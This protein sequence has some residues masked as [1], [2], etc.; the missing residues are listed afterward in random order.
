MLRHFLHY[1]TKQTASTLEF[2]YIYSIHSKKRSVDLDK[3]GRVTSWHLLCLGKPMACGKAHVKQSTKFPD[4]FKH[5][6]RSPGQTFP[7]VFFVGIVTFLFFEEKL[8]F[9]H[10]NLF[11]TEA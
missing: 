4:F 1:I 6:L 3:M 5:N 10:G 2:Q 8:T 7:G 9:L 11:T